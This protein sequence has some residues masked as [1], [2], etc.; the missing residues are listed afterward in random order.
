[1]SGVQSMIERLAI[2]DHQIERMQGLV[3]RALAASHESADL[4]Q[5][6]RVL[7][8]TRS[9]YAARLGQIERAATLSPNDGTN[10]R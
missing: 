1:M 7:I 9:V 3:V 6:L 10:A 4:E 2:L 8:A 5:T